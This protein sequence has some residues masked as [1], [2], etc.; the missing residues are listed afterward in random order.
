MVS[1]DAYEFFKKL[2]EL[3]IEKFKEHVT[4]N[5]LIGLH[6]ARS[7]KKSKK[8]MR[9]QHICFTFQESWTH[10]HVC[11]Y[12]IED[13]AAKKIQISNKEDRNF[14]DLT[15]QNNTNIGGKMSPVINKGTGYTIL[16]IG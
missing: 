4:K 10:N 13:N 16:Y 7:P 6:V 5:K 12:F 2:V 11:G 14:I 9:R 15:P 1:L 3:K 8:K